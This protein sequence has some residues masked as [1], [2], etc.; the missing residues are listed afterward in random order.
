MP[1]GSPMSQ[2]TRPAALFLAIVAGA[3]MGCASS[4]PALYPNG[5]LEDV[6]R[7]QAER[8]IADCRELAENAV[9]G[10]KATDVAKR[11]GEDAVV[12]GATGAAV[13]GIIRGHSAGRGAA[14]GAAAGVVRTV[15]RAAFRWNDPKPIERAWVNRCLHDRGYD[16][17]GWE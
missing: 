5:H 9:G 15:A 14:A 8:D 16:V 2:G 17:L 4:Q 7:A 3:A 10:D 6:G 13:G 11:A 1:H 12:G